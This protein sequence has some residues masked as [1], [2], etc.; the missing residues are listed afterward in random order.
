MKR[1]AKPEWKFLCFLLNLRRYSLTFLLS[2]ILLAR[3][4]LPLIA[5]ASRVNTA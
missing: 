2:V 4:Y 5:I 1:G 3:A